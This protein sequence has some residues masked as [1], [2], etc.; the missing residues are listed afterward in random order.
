MPSADGTVV[1]VGVGWERWAEA[2]ANPGVVGPDAPFGG[3]F[4]VTP[5]GVWTSSQVTTEQRS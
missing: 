3:V 1:V 4:V 5:P 2:G